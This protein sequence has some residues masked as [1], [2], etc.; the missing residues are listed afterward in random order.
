LRAVVVFRVVPR[1]DLAAVVRAGF[2]ALAVVA[3]DRAEVVR[4][5]VARVDVA[6]EAVILP[7]PAFEELPAFAVAVGLLRAVVV[8]FADEPRAVVFFAVELRPPVVFFVVVRPRLVDFPFE[9][10]AFLVERKLLF[11]DEAE[12]FFVEEL[13][14]PADDL[15][16]D[17]PALFFDPLLFFAEEREPV[18]FLVVAIVIYPSK[19][20][21]IGL[22]FTAQ[23]VA[24]GVPI[25][26]Y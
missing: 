15:R 13:F 23:G 18:A 19:F 2:F 16:A 7:F 5:L 14:L 25:F 24:K 1:G 21:G 9:D 10:V 26:L 20:I 8:F 4:E 12:D 6:F 17:E 3:F 22:D 11:F